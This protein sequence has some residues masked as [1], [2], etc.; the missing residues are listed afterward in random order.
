[1]SILG[2]DF[3]HDLARIGRRQRL[4]AVAEERTG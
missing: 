2:P 1:M 4:A 3:W